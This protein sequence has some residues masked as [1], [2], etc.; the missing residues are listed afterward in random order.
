M[1]KSHLSAIIVSV[2]T[3]SLSAKVQQFNIWLS[4]GETSG[5]TIY[6]IP[7]GK[8]YI[9]EEMYINGVTPTPSSVQVSF[10]RRADNI[11]SSSNFFLTLKDT[12]TGGFYVLDK[13]LRLKGGDSVKVPL[14]ATSGS[15]RYFGLLIDEAD[16]YAQN[17]P[18]DLS[19]PRLEGSQLMADAK[20][21]S[22][23][24]RI[25][26]IESSTDLKTM[27]PDPTGTE[28]DTGS[29]DTSMVAVE[30]QSADKKFMRVSAVARP[31]E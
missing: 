12:Y 14:N 19:N 29:K 8:I 4:P 22:P 23:R 13:P 5:P 30:T 24:P 28:T 27:K 11:N 26:K 16:L 9:L 2:L 15:V 3:A 20:F 7:A 25:T 10:S 1:E 18:V 17:I 6:T 31:K 21:A